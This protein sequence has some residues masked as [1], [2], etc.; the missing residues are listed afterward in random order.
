M[1]VAKRTDEECSTLGARA[2][3]AAIADARGLKPSALYVGNMMSGLLSRQTQLGAVLADEAGLRGIEAAAAEAACGS[4]AV[5]ARWGLMA[6]RSGMHD[7]VAVCGTERMTHTERSE[8]SLALATASDWPREG[9]RGDTFVTLN[10]RLMEAYLERYRHDDDVF[11][12]FAINAH[13][14]ACK[15]PNALLHKDVD[16]QAYREG[17]QVC[18]KMRLYDAA[19]I[20][21]G[22][23]CLLLAAEP[24]ARQLEAEGHPVV[25][26]AASGA[27]TDSLGLD[28]RRD[29]LSLDGVRTSAERAFAEAGMLPADIQLFEPHDAFTVI[30]ALSLEACGF[31]RPGE[32]V[33]LAEEIFPGGRLPIATMG[34]LKGRGHPVGASGVYQMVEAALQLTGRAGA[35]QLPGEPR[36]ALTQNLGGT[37]A[38]VVSHI[39]VRDR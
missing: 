6:V 17:R 37:G 31:A 11:A 23:A 12:P 26:I 2:L 34:G 19:P 5:A 27:S 36:V 10:T 20:C 18:G 21:D 25:R 9:A 38:T 7:V 32:G 13:R 35:A 4:G 14:N 15:N 29:L 24:V 30:T 39:L 22:A 16:L 3:A 8:T 28:H 1:P 33:G